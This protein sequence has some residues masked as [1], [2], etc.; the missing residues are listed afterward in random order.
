MKTRC[1]YL[2]EER[3]LDDYHVLPCTIHDDIRTSSSQRLKVI[4][5]PKE[6]NTLTQ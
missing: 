4:G 3:N 6:L 1:L 5:A 2:R